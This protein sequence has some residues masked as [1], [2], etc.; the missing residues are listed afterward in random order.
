MEKTGKRPNFLLWGFILISL[1][2]HLL[3]FLHA[4]G[5]YES[6]AISYIELSM[7]PLD[8]PDVRK[9]P[10]PRRR[11]QAPKAAAIK[12]VQVK[13]VHIPN[14]QVTAME[15]PKLQK[16][17][18]IDLPQLP[19]SMDVAGFSVPG[20]TI[21]NGVANVQVHE[22]PVEFINA[23]DYFEMLHLRIYSFKRY[24]ESARSNHIEGRVKVQ[25]VLSADG[26]LTDIKILKS[27]RHKRLDEAAIEAI[28]RSA[29]FPR[30][31]SFI[32][33]TPVTLRIDILFELA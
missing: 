2:V 24:P 9:I 32:F 8:K 18:R 33:K 17:F 21:A 1:V 28:Q 23:K 15:D 3:V 30:P 26:T 22:A 31:P 5:I 29:P 10:R 20:L 25:F 6:R 14:I 7:H 27:S 16:K 12:T 4:A 13:K 19:G 11:E